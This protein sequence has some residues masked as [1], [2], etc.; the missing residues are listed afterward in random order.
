MG[1][2]LSSLD[3]YETGDLKKLIPDENAFWHASGLGII[4][5]PGDVHEFV[6][7]GQV[8]VVRK[9][10]ERLEG[11]TVKL[12]GGE[13]VP[14]DAMICSTGWKWTCGVKFVP[15]NTHADLGVPSTD[16][17]AE[18]TEMWSRLEREAD[19]EILRK[20]PK[21]ANQPKSARY[22]EQET[23]VA[24]AKEGR[25]KQYTPWRLW[26]GM[27]PPAL[28][29]RSLVFLG[30]VLNLQ[31]AIR[32]EISSLWAYAYLNGQLEDKPRILS[33]RQ[34]PSKGDGS[35]FFSKARR[36]LEEGIKRLVGSIGGEDQPAFQHRTGVYTAQLNTTG[37]LRYETVLF[38]RFGRWRCPCGYGAKFPD[39]AFDG[40]PYYDL[41]LGD[42]G[43]RSWR[44][45]WGWIGEIFGGGYG[46]E[47]YQGVVEE[48]IGKRDG[49]RR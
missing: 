27:A 32:A 16:Y 34:A 47:D 35:D 40:V 18:Q 4:N 24:I 12:A 26:R 13:E 25:E 20:F 37:D 10:I 43:V 14:T 3:C 49:R 46:A 6:R 36:V 44:K 2:R 17:T 31:T 39:F 22:L 11:K 7:S 19:L 45:G 15:E 42:L 41:L 30:M 21:L 48:W 29:D 28:E 8:R 23:T 5:Y 1:I 33:D 9:D 38:N